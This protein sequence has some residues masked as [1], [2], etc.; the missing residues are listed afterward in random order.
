SPA[1]KAQEAVQE[2]YRVGSLLGRGGLGS[3]CMGTRLSDGA[4]VSGGARE[5]WRS[6]S[7]TDGIVVLP[8][9]K[10]TSTPLEIVLPHRVFTGCAG[11]ILL[12]EWA[13]LP[14]SFLLVLEH[15]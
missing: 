15:S 2:R 14:N 7:P 11:V 6:L 9:P 8:Q 4:S 3:V 5:P 12:L 1:G 10:G 13:E